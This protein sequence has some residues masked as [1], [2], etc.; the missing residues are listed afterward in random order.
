MSNRH[1]L[2]VPFSRREFT[3]G[4]SV[5]A[6]AST[7]PAI[8][9]PLKSDKL[10]SH[11]IPK[12]GEML[13]AIGMG[14]WI[15]FNVGRNLIL[16]K[17]R[18]N[19]LQAFFSAGG[20]LVDSSPMYGASEF[21]VGEGLKRTGTGNLFSATKT[22]TSSGEEGKQQ[23]AD[24][25]SLW[26]LEKFD[27]LQ[28]H[29][30]VAWRKHFPYLRELKQQGTI[31]YLGITT[32]HGRRGEEV[33]RILQTEY[34]DFLQLTYNIADRETEAELIPLAREKGVAV[35]CNRPFQGGRLPRICDGHPVPP[36]A[37]ELGCKTWPQLLLKYV[38]STPGV[39]AAIPAT[40]KVAHMQ[41]NMLSLRG[42][43]PNEQQRSWILAAFRD[44]L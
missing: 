29:N 24:S 37:V 4:V 26:G 16:R 13:P 28:V 44:I 22:W 18:T 14:T 30:L 27:L 3:R 1:R 9:E 8:S 25:Q 35:I 38:I 17:R 40:S 10:I 34:V 21:V 32:S 23:F 39:T 31:R 42:E 20:K 36:W 43:L 33:K 41:E 2:P 6:L 7:M 19:V 11:V 12:T 15:T 5:V